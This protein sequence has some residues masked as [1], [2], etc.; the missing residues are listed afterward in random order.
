MTNNIGCD[1]VE[2]AG[3]R[4]GVLLWRVLGTVNQSGNKMNALCTG[5]VDP[6]TQKPL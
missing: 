1:N 6:I 4:G 2:D 5:R 3:A